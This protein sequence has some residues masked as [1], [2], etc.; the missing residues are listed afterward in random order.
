ME[1]EVTSGF[2][3]VKTFERMCREYLANFR[4]RWQG[5]YPNT[6][7]ILLEHMPGKYRGIA[8]DPIQPWV[9]GLRGSGVVEPTEQELAA[10]LFMDELTE[11]GK[12][13]DDFI[14]V[15]DDARRLLEM[16]A[17]PVEREMI[18]ARR[19]DSTDPPP[20]DTVVLGYDPTSFY[21]DEHDSLIA[22][23]AFFRYYQTA[24]IYGPEDEERAR[25]HHARLNMWGLFDTPAHAKE[26]MNS[27]PPT[28]TTRELPDYIA[29]IRAVT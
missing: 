13:Y 28:T 5:K 21:P 23:E 3:I 22:A 2:L 20:P 10:S 4:E 8:R 1:M 25:V 17:P 16:I 7:P 29:E 18:W 27:F 24:D 12:A 11:S 26:Y 14:F 15:L 19:I 9:E 6:E